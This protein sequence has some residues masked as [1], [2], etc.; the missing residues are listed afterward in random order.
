MVFVLS[1]ILDT[2][3]FKLF[4]YFLGHLVI[5]DPIMLVI[6]AAKLTSLPITRASPYKGI[7]ISTCEKFKKKL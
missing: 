3:T 7:G 5:N 6:V 1:Y 2:L 4:A